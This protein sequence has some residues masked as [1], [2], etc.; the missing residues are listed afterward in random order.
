MFRNKINRLS[1]PAINKWKTGALAP[2]QLDVARMG[3]T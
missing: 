1:L 3:A 2:V